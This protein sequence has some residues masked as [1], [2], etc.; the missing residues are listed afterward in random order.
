MAIFLPVIC[1]AI[2]NAMNMNKYQKES[3]AVLLITAD[4][5]IGAW[6]H[7]NHITL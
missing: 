6:I 4:T 7:R 1:P 2:P 5:G 3:P